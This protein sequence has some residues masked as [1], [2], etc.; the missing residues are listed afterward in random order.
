MNR[1]KEYSAAVTG[2]TVKETTSGQTVKETTSKARSAKERNSN[3]IS[4]NARRV[5]ERLDNKSYSLNQKEKIENEFSL[6]NLALT[7][8]L[9][10]VSRIN[11]KF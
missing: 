1:E 3:E 7:P 4:N 10:Y 2:Q 5:N 6:E 8:R 9:R 11:I